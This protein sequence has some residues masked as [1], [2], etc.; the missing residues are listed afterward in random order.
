MGIVKNQINLLKGN[1][2][3]KILQALRLMRGVEELK[4]EVCGNANVSNEELAFKL[5]AM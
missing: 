1:S 3:D 4:K 5:S 2:V